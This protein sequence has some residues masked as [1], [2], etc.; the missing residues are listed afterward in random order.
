MK[1]YLLKF[2]SFLLLLFISSN[3]YSQYVEVDTVQENRYG[4]WVIPADY[5][6]INGIGVGILNWNFESHTKTNGLRIE[7]IGLG[8]VG[9]FNDTP[10]R[11]LNDSLYYKHYKSASYTDLING[12][13]IS[14]FGSITRRGDVNGLTI[15]AINQYFRYIKGAMICP[16]W[17]TTESIKGLQLGGFN[18]AD[19]LRGFQ[20]SV[21]GNSC[22]NGKGVQLSLFDNSSKDFSG[23]QLAVVNVS[24][25]TKGVQI[26]LVNYS[27]EFKG[28]QIGLVNINGKRFLPLINWR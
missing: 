10:V 11:F 1:H 16:G 4:V 20:L 25:K 22:Y 8:I 2:H 27:K 9:V 23:L 3:S 26:G 6:I 13:N 5:K 19:K 17:N 12:I 7:L 15:A 21:A 28:V 14:T 18:Y 24:A